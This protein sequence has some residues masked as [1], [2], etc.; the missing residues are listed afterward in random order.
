MMSAMIAAMSTKTTVI[1]TRSHDRSRPACAGGRR[2]W[3]PPAG[4]NVP[5]NAQ[6]DPLAQ[7][8]P[9]AR[10]RPMNRHTAPL[11]MECAGANKNDHI[12]ARAIAFEPPVMR[13]RA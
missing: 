8:E 11:E 5:P 7:L 3:Y 9:L 6:L 4:M 13:K 2:T 10:E 12:D 1:V